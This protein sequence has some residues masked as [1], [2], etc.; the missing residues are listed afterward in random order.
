MHILLKSKSFYLIIYT[1]IVLLILINNSLKA[2]QE[3]RIIS[4]QISI[5]K[6]KNIIHATGDVLILGEKIH[7][8]SNDIIYEKNIT[9]NTFFNNY[10]CSRLF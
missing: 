7:S 5:D 3:I 2:E 6:E 8:R 10:L 9:R 1:F 4:D